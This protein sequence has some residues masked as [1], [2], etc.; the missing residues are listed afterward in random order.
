MLGLQNQGAENINFVTPTHMIAQILEALPIAIEKGLNLPLVYNCGGYESVETL[1]ILEGVFDIYMP[2]VKYAERM[3]AEKFSQ[4][5]DYWKIA[6]AAVKEMH[7]Q[8]GDL[9]IEGGIAKRGLLIR[10]LVL[11]NRLAGSFKIIDFIR[12]E[13]SPNT[14]INIMDQYYPCHGAYEFNEISRRIT[15][16]EYQ[17]VVEYAKQSGLHRGF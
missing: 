16:P 8:A 10:H 14:Y 13:L 4:A 15:F 9:I 7:R 12:K 2:D 5:A 11:P 3:P 17:E 1:K 6:Q